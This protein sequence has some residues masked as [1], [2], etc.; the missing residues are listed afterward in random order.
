MAKKK[1]SIL[2]IVALAAILVLIVVVVVVMF[3]NRNDKL[4]GKWAFDDITVY[5]FDGDG[6]GRMELPRE[7]YEFDYTINKSKVIIDFDDPAA[8]DKKFTFDIDGSK[9]TLTEDNG[10]SYNL[11]KQD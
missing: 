9:M 10:K 2:P 3:I 5:V 6:E 1:N 11:T 8:V 7:T 4:T